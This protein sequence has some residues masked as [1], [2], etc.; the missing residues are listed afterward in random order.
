MVR[1]ESLIMK[2]S[3]IL[4]SRRGRSWRC[5]IQKSFFFP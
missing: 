2:S 1:S 5:H 3:L 4:K